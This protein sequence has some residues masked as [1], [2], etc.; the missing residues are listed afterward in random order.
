MSY[1]RKCDICKRLETN[2]ELFEYVGDFIMYDLLKTYDLKHHVEDICIDCINRLNNM[3][4]YPV[5]EVKG[6]NC[7]LTEYGERI[8]NENK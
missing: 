4:R 2:V 1:V 7:F 3:H 6:N 5:L 8:K